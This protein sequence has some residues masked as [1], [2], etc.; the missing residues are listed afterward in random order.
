MIFNEQIISIPDGENIT[1]FAMTKDVMALYI[2]NN[3][4]KKKLLKLG[5]IVRCQ[6]QDFTFFGEYIK[7]I[8]NLEKHYHHLH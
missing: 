6:S 8:S 7:Q 2:Y 1:L 4:L 5:S 3:S